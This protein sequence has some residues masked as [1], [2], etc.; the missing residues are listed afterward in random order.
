MDKPLSSEVIN[1]EEG[2][3]VC[4]VL[5]VSGVPVVFEEADNDVVYRQR[6]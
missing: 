3:Q 6:K 4:W 5:R 1:G 2:P